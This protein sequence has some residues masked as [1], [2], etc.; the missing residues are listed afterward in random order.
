MSDT[1]MALPAAGADGFSSQVELV[2][3]AF[4]YQSRFAGSTMVFLIDFPVTESSAFPLL[5]RDVALLSRTG[6][7]I[8]IVPG[9]DEWIEAVLCKYGI[10]CVHAESGVRIIAEEAMPFVEM[11]AFHAANR[12]MTGLSADRVDAVIGNFVRARGLGVSGGVDMQQTGRVDKIY[13]ESLERVL[14]QNMIPILPCIGWSPAGKPYHVPPEE[15]A[16]TVSAALGA[17]KLLIVSAR[18]A[19]RFSSGASVPGYRVPKG[20]AVEEG[21][22]LSRITPAE[23]R[24]ILDILPDRAADGSVGADAAARQFAREI[25]L[26]LRAMETGVERVQLVDGRESGVILRELFSN[27]GAG[28][29]IYADEYESIR[30]LKTRDIADV[31]R[32]MEPLMSRGILLRRSAADIQEKKNDYVV[33]EIDGTVHASG[34]LH[35]WGDGQGEIA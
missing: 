1:T 7:R 32:F 28:T 34:A 11:A 4:L 35:D 15:I 6:F 30:P 18:E 22:R 3:E 25:R 21:G 16:L 29:M 8:V 2:R 20:I 9:A 13:A 19:I 23:A 33:F 27:Q 5:M 17:V 26:A 10:E 14:G 24:A 12:F 31:L